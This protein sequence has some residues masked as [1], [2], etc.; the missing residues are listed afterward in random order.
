MP[1]NADRIRAQSDPAL[2]DPGQFFIERAPYPMAAL[3][4]ANHIVRSVNA[5]LWHLLRKSRE[6]LVGK[7][8]AKFLPEG[9]T[10]LSLLDRVYRTGEAETHAQQKYSHP[11]PF[12][13]S[14]AI[15]PVFSEEDRPEGVIFQVTE[16]AFFH[17]QVSEMNQ[18]LVLS[19]LHQIELT[20]AVETT[21]N[22]RLQR[23]MAERRQTQQ[24]LLRSEKLASA[25]RMSASIAHEIN[26]PLEAVMN[27]LFLARSTAGLPESARQ[28][29][30]IADGELKRIAHITRQ[31]LGFYRESSAP[32][33][34]SVTALLDGVLDLLQAKIKASQATVEKQCNSQLQ[35]MAVLGELRQVLSNLLANSLDAVDGSGSGSGTVKLR[36]SLAPPSSNGKGRI[37]I[38]VADNG[39]GIHAAALS[40][41]FEP[42]FTTKGSI[43][44]GLGLWVSK[45]L[46]EKHG[47]SIR[48]RSSTSGPHRGTAFSIVLPEKPA[49]EIGV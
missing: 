12:F 14:Y 43:G 33:T 36:A 31:T 47:G 39:K 25:G 23:E 30:E 15:W 20:K 37:R 19:E 10:S 42:F 40:R 48:V 6:E 2:S 16:T 5:A 46:V 26:N 9:D 8:F 22:A 45:Q 49:T 28:Y 4:G 24:A 35:M 38:T 32:T 29:L 21:L 3:H 13:S 18:A 41:I 1:E 44:T 7:P 17:Q 27:T 34:F 11:H